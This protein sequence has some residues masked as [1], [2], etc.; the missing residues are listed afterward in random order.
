MCDNPKM[1][2]C[3]ALCD[4]T[5]FQIPKMYD[6]DAPVDMMSLCPKSLTGTG[7]SAMIFFHGGGCIAGSPLITHPDIA[8]NAVE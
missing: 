6:N 7:K 2:E 5:E 3:M 4:K 1:K 8:V